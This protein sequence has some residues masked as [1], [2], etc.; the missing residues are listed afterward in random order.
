M[1][2]WHG[3][4]LLLPWMYSHFFILGVLRQQN[5]TFLPGRSSLVSSLPIQHS[6][7]VMSS[8]FYTEFSQTSEP[9]YNLAWQGYSGWLWW[10]PEGC[11]QIL[12]SPWGQVGSCSGCRQHQW[13]HCPWKESRKKQ[14][15]QQQPKQGH[16]EEAETAAA[17][18]AA[19][20]ECV[21]QGTAGT[22]LGAGWDEGRKKAWTEAL[23]WRHWE[24]MAAEA[25]L[26]FGSSPSQLPSA[27]T[28]A[29]SGFFRSILGKHWCSTCRSGDLYCI[30]KWRHLL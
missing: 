11:V 29:V 30:V 7:L 13:Q 18:A 3:E 2:P 25:F 17:A 4:L 24:V 16:D 8:K 12:W 23:N 26:A 28:K 20:Q 14:K 21:G 6:A 27:A 10:L 19:W 15:Q 5:P 9:Q 22:A 1:S